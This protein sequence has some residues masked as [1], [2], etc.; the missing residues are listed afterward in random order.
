MNA[1]SDRV[2]EKGCLFG[3]SFFID[4]GRRGLGGNVRCKGEKLRT[5][6]KQTPPSVKTVN[7]QSGRAGFSSKG[8]PRFAPGLPCFKLYHVA[9]WDLLLVVSYPLVAC[10][11]R[12]L[13]VERLEP[14]INSDSGPYVHHDLS[15]C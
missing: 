12:C 7:G 8:Q 4:D 13:S 2:Y 10:C 11:E 1:V 14:V 3:Q 5:E 9:F 15:G 6:R